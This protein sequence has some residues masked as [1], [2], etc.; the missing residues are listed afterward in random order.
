LESIAELLID[1]CGFAMIDVRDDGH[2]AEA[3]WKS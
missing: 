3:H 2:I 1:E